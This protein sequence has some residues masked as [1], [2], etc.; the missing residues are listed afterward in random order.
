MLI[1]LGL[2]AI[3]PLA[4]QQ[5]V[6]PG[7]TDVADLFD[8]TKD[9]EQYV[10]VEN[11]KGKVVVRGGGGASIL[12]GK[13][14][15]EFS[16]MYPEVEFDIAGEGSREGVAAVVAGTADLAA[17][18]RPLS[19]G[20]ID[21]VRAV[22]GEEPRM[23]FVAGDAFAL[24]VNVDNPIPRLSL[25]QVRAIYARSLPA[26]VVAP[27]TWGDLGVTGPLAHRLI[28]RYS[29]TAGHS[30][31]DLLR[32]SVLRS[33]PRFDVLYERVPHGLT[34][35]IGADDAGI[36]IASVIFRNKRTR[37]VPVVD[38][39]GREQM[40]TYENLLNG[41]YPFR[42]SI[43]LLPVRKAGERLRPEVVEFLRFT[44][45][46]RGQRIA[47][48]NGNFPIPLDAQQRTWASLK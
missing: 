44:T 39:E 36:G 25:D 32:D 18:S 2:G 48:L 37:I 15:D 31:Y 46:R 16:T 26:G 4:G 40:L 1:L 21:T 13:W 10:V 27:E 29:L 17:V 45:S 47:A 22:A 20:E 5:T 7:I 14:A 35:S 9:L 28:A 42:R 3:P 30:T 33:E 34:S 38:R 12:V 8:Q 24:F 11:L 43:W 23:M 19:A 41:N 6:T